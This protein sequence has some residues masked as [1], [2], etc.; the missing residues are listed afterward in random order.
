M[1]FE[2]DCPGIATN[3]RFLIK[4]IQKFH[5]VDPDVKNISIIFSLDDCNRMQRL[6]RQK[7]TSSLAV[8]VK[9]KGA[10]I[11]GGAGH[12]IFYIKSLIEKLNE[13]FN[14]AVGL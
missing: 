12:K 14:A 11:G 10:R 1:Q 13:I 3:I 7:L 4:C 9:F 8:L 6:H 5:F 2:E